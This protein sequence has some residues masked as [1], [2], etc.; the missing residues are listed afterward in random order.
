MAHAQP[1]RTGKTINRKPKAPRAEVEDVDGLTP[2]P[3]GL[4]GLIQQARQAPG[5]LPSGAVQQLQQAVG[6]QGVRQLLAEEAQPA[7]AG[8]P[9]GLQHGVEQLSGLA[10]DQVTVHYNSPQPAQLG[11]LAFAQGRAIHV[12]PG[13][14]QHLPHEAWHVVQQA[15]GRV[16]PTA[17]LK[18]RVPVNADAALEQ[19]A[20]VMGARAL[21][22]GAQLLGAAQPGAPLQRLEQAEAGAVAQLQHNHKVAVAD[23]PEEMEEIAEKP[24]ARLKSGAGVV[25]CFSPSRIFSGKMF[26]YTARQV[27]PSFPLWRPPS[28]RSNSDSSTTRAR[29]PKLSGRIAWDTAA[30]KWRYQVESIR[31][32]GTIQLVY[33][34]WSHYPAPI[35]NND[36]GPLLNV[37]KHN[38]HTIVADLQANRTGIAGAWS[39]YL[40][41]DLHE[42]YHWF[43]EWIPTITPKFTQAQTE[44]AALGVDDTDAHGQPVSYWDARRQLR[45]QAQQIFAARVQEG[46][47]TFNALGDA[48]GDPPYIAQAPAVDNLITRIQDKAADKGWP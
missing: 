35:P 13:Q 28:K 21:A 10:L 4:A 42:D 11:A 38:W 14:E 2:Q 40:A 34:S 3:A 6:N 30:S 7:S 45:Q 22:Q 5:R 41:E 43:N 1:A 24:K 25:Q 17:Q 15:Q 46:R 39:A 48:P 8:L 18:G 44:I 33:Y 27:Q 19:E 26:D 37:N 31:S 9:A 12:A 20:E 47:A 23:E 29:T 16:P 32:P 36:A